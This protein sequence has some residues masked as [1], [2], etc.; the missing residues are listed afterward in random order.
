MLNEAL[1]L[2]DKLSIPLHDTRLLLQ[3][4]MTSDVHG[5]F[6]EEGLRRLA[7]LALDRVD[8]ALGELE[9]W[10]DERRSL[11]EGNSVSCDEQRAKT[12]AIAS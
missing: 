6:T 11:S 9:G 5:A 1:T 12:A 7:H 3:A 4:I 2:H 10:F 8:M